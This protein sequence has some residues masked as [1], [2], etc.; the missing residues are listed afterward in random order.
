MEPSP[1]GA[2]KFFWRLR[3]RS[4]PSGTFGR[5]AYTPGSTAF[6]PGLLECPPFGAKKAIPRNL[7]LSK[8]HSV[9]SPF[10]SH[11]HSGH[12]PY[13]LRKSGP[14][15]RNRANGATPGWSSLS[16]KIGVASPSF[17][18]NFLSFFCRRLLK[19]LRGQ[20][21][22]ENLAD[23]RSRNPL[24][25]L[26]PSSSSSS[27]SFF[28]LLLPSS[29]FLLPSSFFLLPSSFFLLLLTSSFFLLPSSF[30]LLPSSF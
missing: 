15:M 6:H 30:F 13:F 17:A 9:V 22:K 4:P 29:F 18:R 23:D 24:G 8:C 12:Y 10:P 25:P 1:K 20:T 11:G 26:P 27:S 2:N 7:R 5:C 21:G 19:H 28:L 16:G 14:F 3:L